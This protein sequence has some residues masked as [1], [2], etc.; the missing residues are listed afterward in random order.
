MI[1]LENFGD[2][3]IQLAFFVLA[4]HGFNCKGE[5]VC[6]DG[7]LELDA[8]LVV[9]TG[10]C[11]YFGEYFVGA[12]PELI[13][14]DFTDGKELGQFLEHVLD[15]S[16]MFVHNHFHIFGTQ[17]VRVHVAQYFIR[18]FRVIIYPLLLQLQLLVLSL[19]I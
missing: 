6:F 2:D 9:G 14:D 8:F 19:N 11:E 7:V 18:F 12:I 13:L 10:L 15:G 16:V 4:Q 1:G 3:D 17:V 5:S